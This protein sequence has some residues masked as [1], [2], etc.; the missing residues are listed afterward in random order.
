MNLDRYSRQTVYDPIGRAGQEKLA[1]SRA[2]IL[3]CG[4][5]GTVAAERLTRAGVGFI[6]VADRDWVELSNLQRQ[7]LFT[8]EDARAKMPKAEAAARHLKDIN[9]EIKFEAVAADINASNIAPLCR[10]A[11]VVIDGSDNM[12]LRQLINEERVKTGKPWIYGAAIR[13]G[14][15]V[16]NIFPGETAC[17]K[18]LYPETA[19]AGALP[20]CST[21]GVLNMAAAVVASIQAA[22]AVK[23]LLGAPQ[24]R[25][26]LILIDLWHNAFDCIEVE[27]DPACPV[28]SGGK[29]ELL[30]QAAGVSVTPLCG[31]DAMQVVPFAANIN[32]IKKIDFPGIAERLKKAGEVRYT[33]FMLSFSD[34]FTGVSF[35]LFPDRRAVIFGVTDENRAKAVYAEYIGW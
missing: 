10:D 27:K 16:M 19:P 5:L 26:D 20:A 12:E 21:A 33:R 13:A 11:D 32:N 4:A 18:C 14:G 8:E 7:T 22:E 35:N 25:K 3:G 6:R 1:A 28:C 15:A 23:I 17:L 31:R 29:F 2:A 9:S 34:S 24:A 30:N